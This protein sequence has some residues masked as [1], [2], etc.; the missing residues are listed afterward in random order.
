MKPG[1]LT[2]GRVVSR[3]YFQLVVP[4]FQE[5][6]QLICKTFRRQRMFLQ[7]ISLQIENVTVFLSE[8]D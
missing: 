1:A 7:R 4:E 6:R 3:D 8:R 5:R 2:H